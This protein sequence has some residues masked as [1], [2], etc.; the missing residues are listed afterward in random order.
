M[1]SFSDPES[2]L[3]IYIQ[4]YFFAIFFAEADRDRRDMIGAA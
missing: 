4:F 1:Q 3:N 2:V